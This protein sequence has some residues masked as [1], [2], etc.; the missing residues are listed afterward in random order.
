MST[1]PCLSAHD[2][3]FPGPCSPDVLFALKL[4]TFTPTLIFFIILNMRFY[5]NL[6]I[7]ALAASTLSPALSAPIHY[8]Y[9]NLLVE[10]KH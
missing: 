4:V 7:L 2:L 5:M 1:G 3:D 10:I 8:W 9:G 6:V